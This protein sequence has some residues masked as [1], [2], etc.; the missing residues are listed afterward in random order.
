[1]PVK[2]LR[3]QVERAWKTLA[4]ARF[5]DDDVRIWTKG[6]GRWAR[7]GTSVISLRLYR[8]VELI[9]GGRRRFVCRK[10]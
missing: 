5:R 10:R 7:V 6:D 4:D 1:M 9:A 3:I 8:E 2:S